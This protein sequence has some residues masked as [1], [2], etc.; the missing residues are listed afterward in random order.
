[1]SGYLQRMAAAAVKP[2]RRV[3]PF[4]RPLYEAASEPVN[5]PIGVVTER[6]TER[7]SEVARR[8]PSEATPAIPRAGEASD[9]PRTS[10]TA[11]SRVSGP[12]NQQGG[13]ARR[14]RFQALLPEVAQ[15]SAASPGA[16]LRPSRDEVAEDGAHERQ[17]RNRRREDA[18]H[19]ATRSFE[20]LVKEMQREAYEGADDVSPARKGEAGTNRAPSPVV[21]ENS[22]KAE[23]FAVSG[24]RGTAELA[25]GRRLAQQAIARAA[26]QG[27]DEIRIHIGRI[28]V[29]A[30]PPAT[31]RPVPAPR[32]RSQTLDE[33]LR[34]RNG[35]AG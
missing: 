18:E 29:T 31:P 28:E 34:Q 30:M 27:N 10:E 3:H 24:M 25:A 13:E 6:V 14:D 19:S 21:R 22:A 20:P 5:P 11:N 4:V 12:P 9:R 2:E 35:R 33:Y 16:A 1:M 8:Q 32:R 23:A 17:S 15:E 7:G 26:A